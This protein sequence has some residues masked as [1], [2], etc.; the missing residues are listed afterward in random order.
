[1]IPLPY[2]GDCS[3]FLLHGIPDILCTRLN[4]TPT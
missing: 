2:V 4:K 3:L 1:M